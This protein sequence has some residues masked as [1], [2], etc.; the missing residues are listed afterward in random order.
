MVN[1]SSWKKLQFRKYAICVVLTGMALLLPPLNKAI[2]QTIPNRQE[3][4]KNLT[5]VQKKE[6]TTKF[7]TELGVVIPDKWSDYVAEGIHYLPPDNLEVFITELKK[8][9]ENIPADDQ[10]IYAT[11]VAWFARSSDDNPFLDEEEDSRDYDREAKKSF[12]RIA[13]IIISI[14]EED[15]ARAQE[16]SARIREDNARIREDNAKI[17]EDN[18]RAQ[19]NSARIHQEAEQARL[20]FYK[21]IYLR[22]PSETN[23][24]KVIEFAE[25]GLNR[26]VRYS[27][28]TLEI[29][30]S[31]WIEF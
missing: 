5:S 11:L 9:L 30:K 4:L 14:N 13:T 16:N 3:V 7:A 28:S 10:W 6:I 26:W 24:Q 25:D 19:E 18:A 17:Q 12:D 22:D 23:K 2:A 27:S 15:I 31:L 1:F 21:E 20:R 29:F 8:D